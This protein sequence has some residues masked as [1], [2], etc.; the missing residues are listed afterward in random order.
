MIDVEK[1]PTQSTLGYHRSPPS[2]SYKS[3][4]FLQKMALN[5]DADYYRVSTKLGAYLFLDR[6][7]VSHAKVY[8][9]LD[10]LAKLTPEHLKKPVVVKPLDGCSAVGVMVLKPTK[11]GWYDSIA[12]RTWTFDE[13]VARGRD[14]LDKRGFPDVWLLEE[15]LIADGKV[16]D[17]LKFYT[18]QGDIAL[19]LQRQGRPGRSG[20]LASYRWYDAEWN[21]VETGKHVK[22]TNTDLVLPEKK[23]ELADVARRVSSASPYAFTRVDTFYTDDGP[24]VGE[25][26]A[27]VG[28]YDHFTDEWDERLG[29]VWEA[30]E[31]RVPTDVRPIP[32]SVPEGGYPLRW[33]RF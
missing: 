7:G 4:E 27:W 16:P 3:R 12:K 2:F 15:P 19:V 1:Y 26:N 17:D 21:P 6:I 8:G 9:V 11:K 10:G 13:I 18:F 28:A 22:K 32:K 5:P 25:V 23:E 33:W 20:T 14:A 29:A 24:K 30:A 31:L